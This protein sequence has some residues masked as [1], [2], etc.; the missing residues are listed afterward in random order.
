MC[1]LHAKWLFL[2]ISYY[3]IQG[4]SSPRIMKILLALCMVSMVNNNP[5][6]AGCKTTLSAMLQCG[7]SSIHLHSVKLKKMSSISCI[8]NDKLS[9]SHKLQLFGIYIQGRHDKSAQ[10]EFLSHTLKNK[11]IILIFFYYLIIIYRRG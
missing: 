6:F 3:P 7:Q 8:N 11:V 2:H 4:W 5:I 1:A 10:K 9:I